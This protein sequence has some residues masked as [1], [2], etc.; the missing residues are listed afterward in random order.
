MN[1]LGRTALKALLSPTPVLRALL[2]APLL[3]ASRPA[4][5]Q[6]PAPFSTVAPSTFASLAFLEGTWTAQAEGTGGTKA[7]G[8]YTFARELNGHVLARHGRTADCKPAPGFDCDHSDLLY[9]FQESPAA[10]LKAF[11]LDNEGHVIHYLVTT[12][13][14]ATAVFL[15]DP[16]QPGPVFR[17]TYERSG[18]AMAG[19]FE[20]H[21]PGSP[22][23]HRYLEW[24]GTK[25]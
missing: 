8:T 4:V 13:T 1:F 16:A 11:F 5:A 23:W 9:V 18:S 24:T 10:P 15:S 2:L 6:A 12:P 7:L 22:D 21:M 25:Q 17:L 20:M 14:P 3:A 19:K